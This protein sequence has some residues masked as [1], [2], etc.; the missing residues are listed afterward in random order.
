MKVKQEGN[1]EKFFINITHHSHYSHRTGKSL[2]GTT[3]TNAFDGNIDVNHHLSISEP[4]LFQ[5]LEA[6]RNVYCKLWI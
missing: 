5:E 1:N 6:G 4:V 3:Y 2:M